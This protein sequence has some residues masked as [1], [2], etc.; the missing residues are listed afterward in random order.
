MGHIEPLRPQLINSSTL[1][2]TYSA[3]SGER[4]EGGRGGA[5]AESK[6]KKVWGGMIKGE[7]GGKEGGVRERERVE[8]GWFF[9]MRRSFFVQWGWKGSK[10]QRT[11]PIL[12]LD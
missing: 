12:A 2:T 5:Q 10:Q 3:E 7:G 4:G 9:H 8:I 11:R 6:K 1:V